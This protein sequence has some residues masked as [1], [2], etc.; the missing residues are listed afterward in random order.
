M[1]EHWTNQAPSNP[2]NQP[3]T[4][5]TS[6]FRRYINYL[7]WQVDGAASF[8]LWQATPKMWLVNCCCPLSKESRYQK[9]LVNW[10]PHRKSWGIHQN[11]II[12]LRLQL[13]PPVISIF[14][15]SKRGENAGGMGLWHYGTLWTNW[16]L[17]PATCQW[18][19]KWDL[20]GSQS[21]SLAHLCWLNEM[22]YRFFNMLSLPLPL[23]L[24]SGSCSL[25]LTKYKGVIIF[26]KNCCM[27]LRKSFRFLTR[28]FLLLLY[29]I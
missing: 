21:V 4:P 19:L 7:Y 15:H 17:N 22:L 18:R 27:S 26:H 29:S 20:R 14:L 11:A 13:S 8:G 9:R 25:W 24:P 23:P 5:I 2:A 28:F 3:H 6:H 1:A 12:V 16:Q 10:L